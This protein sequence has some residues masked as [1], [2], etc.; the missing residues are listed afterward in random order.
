MYFRSLVP[1][2]GGGVT[3]TLT[4]PTVPDATWM[5][6]YSSIPNFAPMN[7]QCGHN[8]ILVSPSFAMVEITCDVAVFQSPD[9]NFLISAHLRKSQTQFVNPKSAAGQVGP[10]SERTEVFAAGPRNGYTSRQ[11]VSPKCCASVARCCPR[12]NS[13]GQPAGCPFACASAPRCAKLVLSSQKVSCY[14]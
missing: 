10:F 12:A 9:V 6:A 7:K 14:A 4:F 5:Q 11:P 1:T 3:I 2:V 13:T 8:G